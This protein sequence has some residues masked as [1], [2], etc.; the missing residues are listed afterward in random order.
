MS[1]TTL[2]IIVLLLSFKKH[3]DTLFEITNR[4]PTETLKFKLKELM[5]TIASNPPMNLAEEREWQLALK[6]KTPIL[7]E[8]IKTVV[9]QSPHQVIGLPMMVKKLLKDWTTYQSMGTKM[10]LSYTLDRERKN[11]WS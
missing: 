2:L 3:T 8:L 5:E 6:Q 11:G 1:W 10:I 7:L 9:L 4:K